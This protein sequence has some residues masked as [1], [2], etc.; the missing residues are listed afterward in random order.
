M[1]TLTPTGV[2]NNQFLLSKPTYFVEE[3]VTRSKKTVYFTI[4][5]KLLIFE[6]FTADSI[7]NW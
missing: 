4:C 7:K 6:K 3:K 5:F 1:N 2:A